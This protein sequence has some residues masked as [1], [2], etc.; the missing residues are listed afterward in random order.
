[1][2]T[3]MLAHWPRALP[4][5]Q[6]QVEVRLLSLIVTGTF[7]YNLLEPA[8]YIYYLQTGA[9]HKIATMS[10]ELMWIVGTFILAAA[11]TLP[12]LI[13]LL[14]I[15][16]WM[17]Y[18]F[19]RKMATYAALMAAFVWGFLAT[20]AVPVDIQ[21]LEWFYWLNSAGSLVVG[22]VYGF[23]LNSQQLRE[24]VLDES[25]AVG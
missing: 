9:M 8:W 14:I 7:F 13:S 25:I 19:P 24:K 12:H 6:D 21:G 20:L 18:R 17:G 23:S 2:H 15:P 11:L 1:M 4:H 10:G 22:G 5:D 3:A 16:K